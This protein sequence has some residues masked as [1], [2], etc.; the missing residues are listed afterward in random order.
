MS[1]NFHSKLGRLFTTLQ[2]PVFL[3]RM[4]S[5]MNYG[6]VVARALVNSVCPG[7]LEHIPIVSVFPRRAL[8]REIH[9]SPTTA[10]AQPFPCRIVSAACGFSKLD[11]PSKNSRR[12]PPAAVPHLDKR[13]FGDDACFISYHKASEIWGV[14]DGVGGWRAYGVDPSLFSKKLMD[15]CEM[16]VKTGRFLPEQPADLLASGYQE[17]LEDKKPLVGSSTAC[18]MI[19]DK[20][21]QT[22]HTANLGDSGFRV[23]RKG[24]VVHRSIEQ[25]H[26]FNTPYQLSITPEDSRAE[27]VHDRAEDSDT[28]TFDLQLGDLIL[29]ATDGLFDNMPD[30]EI[31]KKLSELKDNKYESIK[32]TAWS[33]AEHARDL[34][35]DPDYLSPFAKQARRSGMNVIGGKPDDIT[36]LLSMVTGD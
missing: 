4:F 8:Q 5:V 1:V 32:Q 31:L 26:F 35:F 28:A 33:I 29:T 22:M 23:V 12:V 16:L 17:L 20:S 21:K 19:V 36:V 13:V 9:S 30:S 27:M 2:P 6:R 7:D 24:E 15:A 11:S 34:S 18:I 14:A 25:Q 3:S 10:P